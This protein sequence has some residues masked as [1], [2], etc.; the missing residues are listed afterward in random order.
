VLVAG[1]FEKGERQMIEI[2]W[3][4]T[5][6]AGIFVL[7]VGLVTIMNWFDRQ[8]DKIIYTKPKEVKE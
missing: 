1:R 6:A 2:L 7:I 5:V 4:A 3:T 8:I